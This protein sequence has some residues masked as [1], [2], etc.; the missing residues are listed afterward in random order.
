MGLIRGLESCN[1]T[2]TDDDY[3]IAGKLWPVIK[4]MIMTAIENSQNLILEG[5]YIRPEY[6]KDFDS[7]YS[8]EIIP[9]FFCFSQRYIHENYH[10]KIINH[11][12]II[13]KR[14]DEE[15]RDIIFFIN[16]HAQFQNECIKNNQNYFIVEDDFDS[17]IDKIYN[18][19]E[20]ELSNRN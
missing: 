6:L 10:S 2:A 19:I 3:L 11:R 7:D 8:K 15:D 1:F 9:L 14:I 16:E 20:K 5:A 12:N 13:E 4:G 18:Y 17:K